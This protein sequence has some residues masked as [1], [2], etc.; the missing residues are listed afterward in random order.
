MSEEEETGEAGWQFSLLDGVMLGA[1]AVI[2][3][4]LIMRFR[5]KRLEEQNNL[6]NLRVI[7]KSVQLPCVCVCGG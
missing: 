2:L 7:T 5:K 4:V 6:R 3:A 1:L